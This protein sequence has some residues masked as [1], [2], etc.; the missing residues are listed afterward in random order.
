MGGGPS[1]TST[2]TTSKLPP[3]AIG[4]AKKLLGQ[5]F[6]EYFPGG[7][8]LQMPSDLNQ[9]VAGLTPD[10]MSA[11]GLIEGQTG[12][13][14][15]LSQAGLGNIEQTLSGKFLDPSTNPYLQKTYDQAAKALTSNYSSSIAP[16]LMAQA[17][18]AGGGGP[19]ALS[20]NTAFQQAQA[21]NQYGLGENLGNLATDI[22]GGNYQQERGREMQALGLLP[23][24]EQT[25]YQPANQLLAAGTLQQ[26]QQQNVLDAMFQNALRKF[27][28]PQQALSQF[29]SLLGQA[30]GG[31]GQQINVG[32]NPG[33]SK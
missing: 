29:G 10:Q 8:P 20:G 11:L 32:P 3:W 21:R 6:A 33:G 26:S 13:A 31:T 17:Q 16:S 4:Y 19:G 5:G 24:T 14:T 18:R 1:Q 9:Q 7:S 2:T 27:Q 30:V 12:A 25:L 15:G 23:Q 22:Y 28:I